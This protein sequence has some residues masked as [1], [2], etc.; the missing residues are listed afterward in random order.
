MEKLRLKGRLYL[1]ALE[2]YKRKDDKGREY[3]QVKLMQLNEPSQYGS[4]HIV[5]VD[6]WNNGK[7]E[8]KE[9]TA[10]WLEPIF[11]NAQS[12]PTQATPPPAVLPKED[13][14]FLF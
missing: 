1:D 10:C 4:T 13:D 9:P 3:V 11:K 5:I 7:R 14:E 2:N 6:T 12:A 8:E